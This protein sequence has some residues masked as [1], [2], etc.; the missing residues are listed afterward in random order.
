[1]KKPATERGAMTVWSRKTYSDRHQQ[2]SPF[3]GLEQ[4]LPRGGPVHGERRV[5][6]EA[7]SATLFLKGRS[8]RSLNLSSRET[9]EDVSDC[10]EESEQEWID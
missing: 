3:A 1:V 6:L 7:A 10:A 8:S 5:T 9:R 4:T 2:L